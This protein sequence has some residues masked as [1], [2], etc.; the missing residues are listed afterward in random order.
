[1]NL[2]K[3]LLLTSIPLVGLYILISLIL[4]LGGCIDATWSNSPCN[5]PKNYLTIF[6]SYKL[7]CWLGHEK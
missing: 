1:M 3:E 4:T 2:I 7:G 5:H 6:P